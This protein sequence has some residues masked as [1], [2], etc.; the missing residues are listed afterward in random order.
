MFHF[1]SGKRQ[2]TGI[3]KE[4]MKRASSNLKETTRMKPMSIYGAD[5]SEVLTQGATNLQR[6]ST[7]YP[8]S[9]TS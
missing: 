3:S 1:L 9:P 7:L 8:F 5:N 4:N 6:S 2:R